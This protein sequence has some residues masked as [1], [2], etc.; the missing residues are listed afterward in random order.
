MD[1]QAIAFDRGWLALVHEVSVQDSK[2]SYWH[3]FVWFDAA[4]TLRGVSQRFCL[5]QQ[6]VEFA[7]GLARHPD[8][9]RLLISFG[10]RDREAWLATVE[11]EEV[12]AILSDTHGWLATGPGGV[13]AWE[14]LPPAELMAPAA[15]HAMG[16]PVLEF[17]A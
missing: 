16:V 2:R 17:A 9:R 4:F 7:S 14:M 12:R 13:V 10:I 5:Q 3:R 15:R 6:G 8:G 11:A 1:S